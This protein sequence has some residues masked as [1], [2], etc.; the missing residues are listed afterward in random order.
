MSEQI[1]PKVCKTKTKKH[2]VLI[3]IGISTTITTQCF[4]MHNASAY[5]L[6]GLIGFVLSQLVLYSAILSIISLIVA[7]IHRNIRKLWFP[8]LAWLF[9]LAGL[10][11]IVVGGFTE[12]VLRP[13]ANQAI[14]G[15][16]RSGKLEVPQFD[17]RER[18]LGHWSSEDNLTHKY[19]GPNNN[20]I[21]VNLGQRKDLKYRIEDFSV[22]ER[23]IE[24]SVSGA[25]Y[26]PHK[27]MIYFL[28]DGTAWE[29]VESSLGHFKAK[30]KHVG[31][32]ES[33]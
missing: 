4:K 27:R 2:V 5:T 10:F 23:R 6:G 3:L 32:E 1:S 11:D 25:D 19:F 31:P 7:A 15:L 17:P 21:I 8:T 24:F 20:L 13:K 28:D 26:D 22:I 29:I 16:V 14:E 9:L 33:P 12:F 18:I 30:L